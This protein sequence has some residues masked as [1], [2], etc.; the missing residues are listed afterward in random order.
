MA[1]NFDSKS[2]SNISITSSISPVTNSPVTPSITTPTITATV[3]PLA[4]IHIDSK[5]A[6]DITLD[7][8]KAIVYQEI[9]NYLLP[10]QESYARNL[11]ALL[12]LILKVCGLRTAWKINNKQIQIMGID[13]NKMINLVGRDFFNEVIVLIN[14][15][16]EEDDDALLTFQKA[17][18][19]LNA[20]FILICLDLFFKAGIHRCFR[21]NLK[22]FARN[23]Q[24]LTLNNK[25]NNNTTDVNTIMAQFNKDF[26]APNNFD[27]FCKLAEE[28]LALFF[29]EMLGQNKLTRLLAIFFI[30]PISFNIE[31]TANFMQNNPLE[32]VTNGTPAD[33]AR[34]TDK[35]S[36]SKS[37]AFIENIQVFSEV[38][39]II[40]NS[41]NS[42]QSVHSIQIDSPKHEG[43]FRINNKEDIE[44]AFFAFLQTKISSQLTRNSMAYPKAL[45]EREAKKIDEKIKIAVPRNSRTNTILIELM[46]VSVD[47]P[48]SASDQTKA[49]NVPNIS[50]EKSSAAYQPLKTHTIHD[51]FSFLKEKTIVDK[52]TAG[53]ILQ[54]LRQAKTGGYLINP[55]TLERVEKNTVDVR[56]QVIAMQV[57]DNMVNIGCCPPEQEKR[58]ALLTHNP[59][60][61]STRV[62]AAI[63]AGKQILRVMPDSAQQNGALILFI[64]EMIIAPTLFGKGFY[65]LRNPKK[66]IT[67][68]I[69]VLEAVAETAVIFSYTLGLAIT[70]FYF[71][72]KKNTNDASFPSLTVLMN[73][74]VSGPMGAAI[75][76]LIWNS[77]SLE[78]KLKRFPE[79]SRR[80]Y[81]RKGF[82]FISAFVYHAGIFRLM[83]VAP[84]QAAG[85]DFVEGW[86]KL[87]VDL[88]PLVPA[89]LTSW[90]RFY[91]PWAERV[92]ALTLNFCSAS[93][94]LFLLRDLCGWFGSQDPEL[95]GRALNITRATMWSSLGVSSIAVL[96]KEGKRFIQ[97]YNPDDA[98]LG[99]FTKRI[100]VP[101]EKGLAVNKEDRRDEKR[102]GLK[103]R[104]LIATETL[105]DAEH[106]IMVEGLRSP[107]NKTKRTSVKIALSAFEKSKKANRKRE[108]EEVGAAS[109]PLKPDEIDEP[110]KKSKCRDCSKCIIS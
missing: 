32:F 82:D 56:Y 11:S 34:P 16:L 94:I 41:F 5:E 102:K 3:T 23:L 39:K 4:P 10:I 93:F 76:Y 99:I 85:I 60:V 2:D 35:Q 71:D 47:D 79:N 89:V 61:Q 65:V 106:S 12:N 6:A 43:D 109:L 97:E 68:E 55:K 27:S 31:A 8:I 49:H 67:K 17:E 7:G 52:K 37:D 63:Y 48:I 87:L 15:E 19:I 98:T 57:S 51:Q 36:R 59:L 100:L 83:L 73:L 14:R 66:P 64:M 25:P 78:S 92:N 81:I 96:I 77:I 9:E 105:S 44:P 30:D 45:I 62:L 110:Q 104:L 26:I 90:A 80:R 22:R 88:G 1:A 50:L 53:E 24:V 69:R 75:F 13:E 107:D 38:F 74:I 86:K 58:A 18:V 108:Q 103:D 95:L 70:S 29:S 84:F 28:E 46:G 42:T 54:A 72:P 101:I 20:H 33:T 91:T 40:K 21:E